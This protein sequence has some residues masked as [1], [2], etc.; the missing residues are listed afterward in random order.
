MA[1]GKGVDNYEKTIIRSIHIDINED[2]ISRHFVN[3]SYD[4]LL[5]V[6]LDSVDANYLVIFPNLDSLHLKPLSKKE[7]NEILISVDTYQIMNDITGIGET[8]FVWEEFNPYLIDEYK[9]LEEWSFNPKSGKITSKIK[10]I[11]P[12]KRAPDKNG[13]NIEKVLFWFRFDDL[14]SILAKYNSYNPENT[15]SRYIWANYFSR[16]ETKQ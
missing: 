4:C 1:Q 14:K 13:R 9:I 16:P 7:I 5:Q 11:A 8:K 3:Y 15:L 12:V 10:G 2:T 6:L